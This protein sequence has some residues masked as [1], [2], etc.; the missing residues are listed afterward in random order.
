MKI[1]TIGGYEKV[2]GNM[3]AVDVDDRIVIFDMG[4]DIEKTKQSGK[5]WGT[6][7]RKE[8]IKMEAIPDD[9]ELKQKKNEVVAIVVGHGHQDHCLG[10]PKLADDY[11][12][13]IIATPYT[14]STIRRIVEN[15][16]EKVNNELVALNPGE[17]YEIASDLELEFVPITH[18]IPQTVIPVLKTGEGLLVYSLDFKIDDEP[19]L[20]DPFDEIKFNEL[21][22][23]GIRALIVD[24]TRVDEPGVTSSESQVR[25]DLERV[26]DKT[27]NEETGAMIT[28]F[29]S[30][31]ARIK[32]IIAAN[33]GRRKIA[34]LG[35]SLKEYLTDAEEHGLIDLSDIKITKN[36]FEIE[37]LLSKASKNKSEYLLLV[38]GSQGEPNAI[39]SRISRDEYPYNLEAGEVVIFS[40]SIIPTSTDV[41]NNSLLK[42]RLQ[43]KGV[44]IENDVHSHG[45][46]RRMDHLR[47]F[48]ILDPETVIP[49]HGGKNKQSSCAE[50]AREENIDSV[51]VSKN[52]ETIFLD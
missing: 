49:A 23:E 3:T 14:I 40:S 39:L 13:P 32:N 24:C 44:K 12:C 26:L 33:Q 35:R 36:H 42:R 52:K 43:K 28:T 2:G 34:A 1:H 46:G 31:I 4:A 9:S 18:S 37:R 30:H 19:T 48:R 11:D 51:L 22:R 16:V 15:D 5:N 38:T 47:L 10:I 8:A 45:H 25:D 41:F 6:I 29:S 17:T 20:G 21:R 7:T 27:Y 50:L